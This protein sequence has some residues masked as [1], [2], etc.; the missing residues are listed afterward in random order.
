MNKRHHI[1]S[2]EIQKDIAKNTDVSDKKDKERYDA[3]IRFK[4]T[5]EE[6]EE[7]VK[8]YNGKVKVSESKTGK[9]LTFITKKPI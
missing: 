5:K 4:G 3:W 9:L 6:A 8:P 2:N 1:S 7:Y